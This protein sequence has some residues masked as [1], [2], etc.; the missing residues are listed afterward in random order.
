[1]PSPDMTA[2][3]C[4]S[5]NSFM[6]ITVTWAVNFICE[7]LCANLRKVGGIGYHQGPGSVVLDFER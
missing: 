1:L 2:F 4:G 3:P 5:S 6:G 7:N